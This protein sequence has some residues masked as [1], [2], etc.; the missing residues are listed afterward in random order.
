MN[1]RQYTA[2]VFVRGGASVLVRA[3]RPD[4]KERLLAA[5][6]RLSDQSVYFRFL[7]AKQNLSAKELAYFTEVDFDRHVSLIATVQEKEL[8]R[9]VASGR[10]IVTDSFGKRAEVAF[11]VADDYQGQGIAPL[12]L[13]HLAKIASEK[14][15]SAFEA[16]V[17][18]ENS[19]MLEVFAKSGFDL[20]QSMESGSV[21][22]V[23][24]ISEPN[25]RI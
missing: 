6:H 21:H 9:I 16:E 2:N 10:Y 24:S 19:K 12:L 18:G 1:L 23:M 25:H 14:G 8:E 11:T 15:V 5:F 13:Q 20:R 4:D 17:H 3:I 7:R 22:A